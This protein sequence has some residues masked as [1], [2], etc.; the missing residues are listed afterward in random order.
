MPTTAPPEAAEL[1]KAQFGPNCDLAL[2]RSA[3]HVKYL[4]QKKEVWVNFLSGDF[5]GDGVPDAALVARCASP[6]AGE[7]GFDYKVED[8]YFAA[9]GYGNPK[10]TAAFQTGDPEHQNVVLVI[11]GAGAE[12]WHA[13]K[14]K[15]KYL[16][17]NLPFDN[18]Q[19]MQ[20][21]AKKKKDK[22]V[23]ALSLLEGEGA[24]N[25]V[26]FFDGKKWRWR[27]LGSQ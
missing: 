20:V 22:P 2:E 5:D 3:V 8:P 13:A 4:S 6:L 19:L 26:A 1:V 10:I 18:L 24:Q 23:A 17:I 27:D 11:L 9:N 12:G 15:A 21:A 25:S 14:P 16:L 7:V